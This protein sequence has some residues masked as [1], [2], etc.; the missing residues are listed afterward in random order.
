LAPSFYL[1]API[2]STAKDLGIYLSA[3]KSGDSD[4]KAIR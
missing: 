3:I 1:S 2:L 4:K